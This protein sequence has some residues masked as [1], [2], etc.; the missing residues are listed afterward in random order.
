MIT[1]FLII[2]FTCPK[3]SV[4]KHSAHYH[5]YS[6]KHSTHYSSNT[7]AVFFFLSYHF[8]FIKTS[9][10]SNPLSHSHFYNVSL[11]I[12]FGSYSPPSQKLKEKDFLLLFLWFL[13]QRLLRLLFFLIL[14][15]TSLSNTSFCFWNTH[16][17][18][19]FLS[20]CLGLCSSDGFRT[21]TT[22]GHDRF[23]GLCHDSS[24]EIA[25]GWGDDP[26][27]PDNDHRGTGI[28]GGRFGQGVCL[29]SWGAQSTQ[30]GSRSSSR[31]L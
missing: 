21:S 30:S 26:G 17:C 11:S 8:F 10:S 31:L 24:G 6:S 5:I 4:K 25:R 15:S 14:L 2:I 23:V 9:L 27:C 12:V 18:L 19:F 20:L 29:G 22:A 28:D 13:S 3:H 16:L 7:I 1:L